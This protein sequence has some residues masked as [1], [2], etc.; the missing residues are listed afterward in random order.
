MPKMFIAF[1]IVCCLKL[2]STF[3]VRH[4]DED[5][6]R[7]VL[8]TNARK[9]LDDKIVQIYISNFKDLAILTED[10][11]YLALSTLYKKRG[12]SSQLKKSGLPPIEELLFNRLFSFTS[13][14]IRFRVLSLATKDNF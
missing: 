1:L 12:Y 7:Y 8:L 14:T 13:D 11:Q 9:I 10:E 3:C 6:L 4:S 5:L 2:S